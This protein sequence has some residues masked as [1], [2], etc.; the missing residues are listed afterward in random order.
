MD[1]IVDEICAEIAEGMCGAASDYGWGSVVNA[2]QETQFGDVDD[3]IWSQVDGIADGEAEGVEGG[4]AVSEIAMV[5]SEIL[6]TA[7]NICSNIREAAAA[8]E[9]IF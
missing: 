8:A 1:E 5:C 2:G 9:W 6:E 3:Q 4:D 7:A